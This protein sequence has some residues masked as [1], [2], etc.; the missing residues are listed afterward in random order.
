[1]FD[2]VG[3]ILCPLSRAFQRVADLVYRVLQV[4][5]LL[6]VERQRV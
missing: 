4:V 6:L 1:M 3:V 2:D 5:D